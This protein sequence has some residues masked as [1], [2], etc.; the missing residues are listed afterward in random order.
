[1]QCQIQ[2]SFFSGNPR[3]ALNFRLKILIWL[4]WGTFATPKLFISNNTNEN[5]EVVI[6]EIPAR[7]HS[8]A[9]Q[10]SHSD[11]HKLWAEWADVA[12]STFGL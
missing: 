8:R 11:E 12:G 6:R 2:M 7:S 3:I 10:E 4:S 5:E 1:M 9:A